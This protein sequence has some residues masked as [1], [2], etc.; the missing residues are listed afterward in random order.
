MFI[1]LFYLIKKNTIVNTFSVKISKNKPI[2]KLKE[3]IKVKNA[4]T[5]ANINIKDIKL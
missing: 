4:Q 2:N 5:F 1:T 3:A